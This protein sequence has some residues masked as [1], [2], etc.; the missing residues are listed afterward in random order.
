MRRFAV[1]LV[2]VV[3][4]AAWASGALEVGPGKTYSTIQAAID[5]AA[6]GSEI[7][8]YEGTYVETVAI[9]GL[10]NL[11]IH[12]A[13]TDQVT[14]K[15]TFNLSSP[16]STIV[17]ENNLV[18]GLYF[19]KRGASSGWAVQH[20]YARNNTYKN[21]VFYGDGS[22][23]SGIYG[24]LSYGLN[25]ARHSTFYGLG[26]PYSAGYGN[27]L[28]VFD[29]IVAFNL[30]Q[31]YNYSGWNGVAKYSNYYNNPDIPNLPTYVGDTTGTVTGN[32]QFYSTDPASEYFLYLNPGSPG[33]ET[34]EDGLNMG[35]LPTVPEPISV[36]LLGLGAFV[37]RK[38]S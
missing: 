21:C 20:S 28:H 33:H 30:Y 36:L 19:D 27:G 31:P 4:M 16:T 7:I 25:L 5:A 6:D 35:A 3:L 26:S 17:C 1:A 13:G 2:L 32:P 15:G 11:N 29:S 37:W 23:A 22:G 38:R 14:V 10:S 8:I 12:A 34:A 18:E 24:N 9:T